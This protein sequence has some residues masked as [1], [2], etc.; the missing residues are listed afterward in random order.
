MESLKAARSK[1]VGSPPWEKCLSPCCLVLVFFLFVCLF[2]LILLRLHCLA[3]IPFILH[4]VNDSLKIYFGQ[5]IFA[6]QLRFYPQNFKKLF[7][8][9]LLSTLLQMRV[10][11]CK[12]WANR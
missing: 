9:I 10:T 12:V 5:R 1:A 11:Y 4:S 3:E 8:A 2:F 6:T 7:V